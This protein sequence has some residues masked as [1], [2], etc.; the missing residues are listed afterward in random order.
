MDASKGK[1][2][3]DFFAFSY[4]QSIVVYFKTSTLYFSTEIL[5]TILSLIFYYL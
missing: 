1:K 2:N 4:I 3:L 5:A